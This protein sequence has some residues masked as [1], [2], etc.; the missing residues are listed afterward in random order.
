MDDSL[1][2]SGEFDI[3]FC[4]NVII[5]FDKITQERVINKLCEKLKLG[6]YFFLGH[7]ESITNMRVPLKQLKP[8][9]FRKVG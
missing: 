5:Y 7:S 1:S 3:I 2:I 4:R 9:V 8:T 6:G